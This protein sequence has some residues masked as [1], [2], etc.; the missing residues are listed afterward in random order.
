M[1]NNLE[2]SER[3]EKD[4]F[5]TPKV[6]MRGRGRSTKDEL[7]MRVRSSSTSILEYVSRGNE[8]ESETLTTK[9]KREEKEKA[10]DI[11]KRSNKLDRSPPEMRKTKEGGEERVKDKEEG[12]AL[13]EI[14]KEIK[15]EMSD[16]RKEIREMK[17]K[18]SN[19]EK[20]WNKRERRLEGRMDKVEERLLK[21]EQEK[22][23]KEREEDRG[24]MEELAERVMEIVMKRERSTDVLEPKI[25]EETRGEVRRLKS[26]MEEIEKKERRNNLVI[27][28][29]KKEKKS[30]KETAMEFLEKEFGAKEGV[31][32]MHAVGKE[33]KEVIIIEMKSW[34]QKEE[35]MREKK[36][37]GSRRIYIDHDMTEEEREVQRKL[38]ERAK[39]EKADGRMVKVGYKKIE[40]QGKKYVWSEEESRIIE[41]INLF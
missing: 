25:L 35:I 13:F 34:E 37:L 18:M 15:E 4:I 41:K 38:R 22:G 6:E 30:I 27:R 28:G 40:I 12:G 10:Q 33:G 29:L 21:V 24:G 8:K 11:F 1:D 17:E 7:R 16:M 2:T 20:G 36:K 9:R 19:L 5:F 39:K 32:R 31:K 23:N 26:A 3:M 14:L